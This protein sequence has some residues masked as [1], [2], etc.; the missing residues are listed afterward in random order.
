MIKIAFI[1]DGIPQN[2]QERY[3]DLRI[4]YYEIHKKNIRRQTML[5]QKKKMTH[6]G[7]CF[8]VYSYY[9]KSEADVYSID[10]GIRRRGKIEDLISAL[11]WCIHEKIQIINLSVGSRNYWDAFLLEPILKNM[12]AKNI[13]VIAAHSNDFSF[14]FPAVSGYTVSTRF[15][16]KDLLEEKGVAIVEG[17]FSD[18]EVLISDDYILSELTEYTDLDEECNSFSAPVISAFITDCYEEAYRNPKKYLYRR[19]GTVDKNLLWS[20]KRSYIDENKSGDIPVVIFDANRVNLQMVREI[21]E[22]YLKQKYTVL[23][24][25]EERTENELPFFDIAN[26]LDV[27]KHDVVK[28][29]LFSECYSNV[30]LVLLHL[31][32]AKTRELITSGMA[33]VFIPDCGRIE[34]EHSSVRVEN[35]EQMKRILQHYL[36]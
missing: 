17:L 14:S 28:A 35:I 11:E 34:T 4:Q 18:I 21:T 26:I 3:P 33:D 13:I 36:L 12:R 5:R 32:S 16:R 2:L 30:D 20:I 10:I 1:D 25:S 31:K 22:F 29:V 15:A 6:A 8:M 24:L 7:L 23:T 9:L 19:Y 27:C